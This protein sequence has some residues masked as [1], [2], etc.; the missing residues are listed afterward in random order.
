[1]RV[2]AEQRLPKVGEGRACQNW[3]AEPGLYSARLQE[4][5]SPIATNTTKPK[6]KKKN[7]M[8]KTNQKNHKKAEKMYHY[9]DYVSGY[10]MKGIPPY[11][12]EQLDKLDIQESPLPL[13][14]G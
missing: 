13:N 6:D 7:K 1:M 9:V 8:K 10:R 5:Y 11:L 3:R 2:K 14:I 4:S 12:V